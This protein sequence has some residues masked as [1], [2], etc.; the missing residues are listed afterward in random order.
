M[1]L[2]S[3]TSVRK[4]SLATT[5]ARKS[6]SDEMS[7]GDVLRKAKKNLLVTL[8]LQIVLVVLLLV[9]IFLAY[10]YGYIELLIGKLIDLMG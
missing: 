1:I 2:K 7:V 5:T 6:N 4:P 10:Y 9:G 3:H 8:I